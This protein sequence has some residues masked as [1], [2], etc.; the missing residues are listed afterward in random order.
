M[1]SVE[2]VYSTDFQQETTNRGFSLAKVDFAADV[3]FTVERG[4]RQIRC[5]ASADGGWKL[6]EVPAAMMWAKT[7]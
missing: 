6:V 2:E 5:P 3:R 7:T 1:A 4:N